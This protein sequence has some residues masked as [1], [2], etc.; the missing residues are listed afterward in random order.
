MI[1]K[2][3]HHAMNVILSEAEHFAIRCGNNYTFQLQDILCI[4][5]VTDIIPAAR[6]IFD[7]NIHPQ[8][9]HSVAISQ[10]LKMFFI[11]IVQVTSNSSLILWSIRSQNDFRLSLLSLSS[12]HGSLV[13]KK[14]V[15]TLSVN[16]R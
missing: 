13:E 7:S 2:N 16:N 6:K 12:L 14:S 10:D 9:L 8:Q 4:V 15:M 3:I 11:G 5:I 1:V